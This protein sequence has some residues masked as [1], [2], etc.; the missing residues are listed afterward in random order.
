MKVKFTRNMKRDGCQGSVNRD[1][2]NESAWFSSRSNVNDIPAIAE[3]F[4]GDTLE[5]EWDEAV[6]CRII[7]EGLSPPWTDCAEPVRIIDHGVDTSPS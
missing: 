4:R 5:D 7:T 1:P 3:S 6:T 2:H